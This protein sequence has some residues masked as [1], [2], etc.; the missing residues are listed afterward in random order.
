MNDQQ[1]DEVVARLAT[2]LQEVREAKG[3]SMNQL[4]GLAGLDQVAISRIE[5]GDRSPGLRTVLKIADALEVKL[6]EELRTLGQ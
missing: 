5:K 2:R 4:A 6:S 1:A 3:L